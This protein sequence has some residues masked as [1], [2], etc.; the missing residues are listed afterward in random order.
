MVTDPPAFIKRKK[1]LRTGTEAYQRLNRLAMR[2][3][4]QDGILVSS[5]CS[6]RLSGETLMNLLW[7]GARHNDR[8]LQ[9]LEQGRQ[10]PDHPIH[11]ALP[12][13]GYLKTVTA[14]VFTG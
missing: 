1:D 5:S 4:T 12:E 10:A 3:L 9:I 7:S 11:P 14:R 6:Y 8:N 13:T 2:V